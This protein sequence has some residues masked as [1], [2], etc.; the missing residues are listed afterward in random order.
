PPR[1]RCSRLVARAR[2][3]SLL[4]AR[5]Q[6]GDRAIE[7]RIRREAALPDARP[8][9]RSAE[10][11]EG[12]E[13]TEVAL[14]AGALEE[15]RLVLAGRVPEQDR[16]RRGRRRARGH[17]G[18][19]QEVRGPPGALRPSALC[20]HVVEDVGAVAPQPGPERVEDGGGFGEAFELQPHRDGPDRRRDLA[21]A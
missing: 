3:L 12:D 21:V 7:L 18:I 14:L 5:A 17:L 13:R 20:D 1:R 8:A 19:A 6:G 16:D 10:D 9:R 11:L 2:G 4:L 15:P